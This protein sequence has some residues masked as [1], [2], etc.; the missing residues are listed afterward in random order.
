MQRKISVSFSDRWFPQNKLH[1]RIRQ[2]LTS[3]HQSR[4]R[5]LRLSRVSYLRRRTLY[6]S[7]YLASRRN[8]FS[9]WMHRYALAN[10]P[11]FPCPAPKRSTNDRAH[12]HCRPSRESP[13]KLTIYTVDCNS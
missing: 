5:P 4:V 12:E 8:D 9:T 7:R 10:W 11:N 1:F 3:T 13:M 2:P 6:E